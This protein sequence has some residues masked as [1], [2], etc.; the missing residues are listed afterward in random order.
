MSIRQ[1]FVVVAASA[2][3][4]FG[5]LASTVGTAHADET[6]KAGA[7][8]PK[9]K[10]NTKPA[11]TPAPAPAR[12]AG[13]G[14]GRHGKPDAKPDGGDAGSGSSSGSATTAA[15][16]GTGASGKPD[17]T[18][19]TGA[20]TAGRGKDG[21]PQRSTTTTDAAR[22]TSRSN[23]PAPENGERSTPKQAA[24]RE[25]RIEFD[26]RT[27]SGQSATGAVYLFQRS[28]SD[29]KSIVEVPDSFRARTLVLLQTPARGENP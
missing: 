29:F 24:E 1:G 9:P 23:T 27:V 14:A 4:S 15:A 22:M 26:E 12:G 7:A 2:L 5:S 8:A 17:A 16:G 19:T 21:K 11:A 25:S 18:T 28:P 6:P 13:H 3:V 20:T 10:G